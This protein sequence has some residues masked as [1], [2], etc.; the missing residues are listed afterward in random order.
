VCVSKPVSQSVNQAQ[1]VRESFAHS[2]GLSGRSFVSQSRVNNWSVS[3]SVSQ[4]VTSAVNKSVSQPDC[5]SFS[6]PLRESVGQ[7]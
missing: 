7:P 3:Q 6:Q 2:L 4:S 1:S 5:Q